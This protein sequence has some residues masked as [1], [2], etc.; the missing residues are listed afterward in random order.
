MYPSVSRRPSKGV[1]F[2]DWLEA[3]WASQS[4][5]RY[6]GGWHKYQVTLQFSNFS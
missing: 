3:E 4:K 2:G 1:S 6:G 5:G